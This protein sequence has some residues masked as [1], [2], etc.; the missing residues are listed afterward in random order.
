ME[1]FIDPPLTEQTIEYP[2][3]VP[4]DP[5][6]IGPLVKVRFWPSKL[7]ELKPPPKPLPLKF[8]PV[9][10]QEKLTPPVEIVIV[11]GEH[12]VALFSLWPPQSP[13]T[14][15]VKLP[16]HVPIRDEGREDGDGPEDGVNVALPPMAKRVCGMGE[17]LG[18]VIAPPPPHMVPEGV[19]TRFGGLPVPDTEQLK[20][21]RGARPA[22]SHPSPLWTVTEIACPVAVPEK[23]QLP[24]SKP[25]EA[26][27]VTE[28]PVWLKQKLSGQVVCELTGQEEA[29]EIWLKLRAPLQ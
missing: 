2:E 20:L 19:Q 28:F 18:Q 17:P 22:L 10:R 6:A 14:F 11:A 7:A 24:K 25:Q 13:E 29:E 27:P 26:V 15:S 16:L 8:V 3:A 5:H 23:L 9:P 21:D 1:Q 12:G 4:A